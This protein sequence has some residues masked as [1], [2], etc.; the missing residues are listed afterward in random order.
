[1]V[2]ALTSIKQAIQDVSEYV[3]STAAAVQQQSAVTSEM[4]EG[5]QR[6]AAEAAGIGQAA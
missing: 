5:M 2:A 1:V 6:A 4:S 3:T